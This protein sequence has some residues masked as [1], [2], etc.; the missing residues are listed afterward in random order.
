MT[1]AAAIGLVLDCHD[2]DAL[3]SFWA[4]ALGYTQ[5]GTAENYAMLVPNDGPGPKLLLQR[6]PENKQLKNRC[7]WTS[8]PTTSKPSP[9]P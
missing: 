5:L 7:T 9:P 3:A 1:T 8:R 6:V 2:P 4:A